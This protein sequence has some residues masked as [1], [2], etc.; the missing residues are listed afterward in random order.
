[1]DNYILGKNDNIVEH[2][3][4]F[5]EEALLKNFKKMQE[6][7][8]KIQVGI[9]IDITASMQS[10]IDS[11]KES[12]NN[13]FITTK[14]LFKNIDI[15]VVGYRDKKDEERVVIQ[16]FIPSDGIK[17]DKFTAKG[18]DDLCEDI[19]YGLEKILTLSW[20]KDYIKSLIIITDAPSHGTAYYDSSPGDTYP[21][22]HKNDKN[23][24][25][26]VR[27][28]AKKK[29]N[30]YV[31]QFSN[32][33]IKMNEIIKQEFKTVTNSL[34]CEI[35]VSENINNNKESLSM[36][37]EKYFKKTI[38]SSIKSTVMQVNINV[39]KQSNDDDYN[40][41][42][43]CSEDEDAPGANFSELKVYTE[44]E[45]LFK[46]IIYDY[47]YAYK[48][49]P[50]FD[51]KNFQVYQKEDINNGNLY[52]YSVTTPSIGDG[53]FRKASIF[54]GVDNNGELNFDEKYIA[55][56]YKKVIDNNLLE[57]HQEVC[58]LSKLFFEHF[59]ESYKLLMKKSLPISYLYSDVIVCKG[60]PQAKN[61]PFSLNSKL[62]IEKMINLS[63]FKKYSNNS[64]Y[65]SEEKSVAN[66]IAQAFSHYSFVYSN[67]EFIIVD[68]QGDDKY[69]TD[70]AISSMTNRYA[71]LDRGMQG[72]AEFFFIH[73]CNSICKKFGLE[74]YV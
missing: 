20:N 63:K 31:W 37:M 61:I 14:Q 47:Q 38:M 40:L 35:I 71:T 33:T 64:I 39:V 26:W 36:S 49:S 42:T 65:V 17:W 18:G 28:I 58:I 51:F 53:T 41:L 59:K 32:T 46:K 43:E 12:L 8:I 68:I 56:Y 60:T 3:F 10:Y 55:K 21:D 6:I 24:E 62:Q 25:Y 30:L 48:V 5:N 4:K 45:L 13:M 73:R 1:M 7:K 29:I 34:N 74:K 72:I 2:I 52:K 19:P 11:C 22:D 57:K 9:L 44:E 50:S 66:N 67:G 16:D 27:E 15:G 23:L 69:F 70:P 54:V